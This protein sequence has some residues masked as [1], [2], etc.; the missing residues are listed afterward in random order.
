MDS[1]EKAIDS[2][3]T[4]N[5]TDLQKQLDVQSLAVF[6]TQSSSLESRKKLADQTRVQIKSLLKEYQNEIDSINKRSKNA[7]SAFLNL[8]KVFAEVADPYPILLELKNNSEQKNQLEELK[9]ENRK[10]YKQMDDLNDKLANDKKNESQITELKQQV[11]QY[12]LLLEARVNEKVA[13]L[14]MELKGEFD[15]RI[16][17][18]KE[19]E[20]SLNRQLSHLK[21]QMTSLKSNQ[22]LNST[23][24][25]DHYNEDLALKL[26]DMDI[27]QLDLEKANAKN[28]TLQ[29]QII[30]LKNEI[31]KLSNQS[32]L[33][34]TEK[35]VDNYKNQIQEL[36]SQI[37]SI[38]KTNKHDQEV[39]KVKVVE[40]ERQVATKQVEIKQ[41]ETLL[42]EYSDYEEIKRELEIMKGVEIEQT[43]DNLP[44][45]RMLLDKNKKLENENI[46]LKNELSNV[47]DSLEKTKD[48]HSKLQFETKQKSSL[49]AKLESDIHRLNE[50]TPH[51]PNEHLEQ[52]M[53]DFNPTKPKNDSSIIPILTSQRDRYRQ[54]YEESQLE[55]RSL[56]QKIS[57]LSDQINSLKQDNISLYEKLKYQ[58]SY[59]IDVDVNKYKNMYEERIDPFQQFKQ[60]E[61]KRASNLNTL[62]QIALE[63]TK[64]LVGNK[65]S[66]VIFVVYAA[67]LHLL[68]FVSLWELMAI[69]SC[70]AKVPAVTES[71]SKLNVD[72]KTS[73]VA[74]PNPAANVA[75]PATQAA[76]QSTPAAQL[77]P[78]KGVKE[79]IKKLKIE[80]LEIRNTLGTGSFG[81]VHLVK[82]KPTGK[83]YAMKV[84]KKAEIIKLRQVEH[85]M[86]EKNILEQLDFPFLVKI[87]GTFQ[88]SN[89]LYLV[90]EYVQGGELFTYLRKSGRFP[91]HVARFYAA[92]VVMAFEYL[93]GKDIIYRDLKP[94]NLLIDHLGHIKITDF[95]FAKFV[96]DVTWTLCGTPDYLAPEIIQS[97]GYGRAVDWWAL[98]ILIYEMIAGHPPFYDEDHF[99]LYEKILG[100]KL[101]FPSHFDPLAKDLVKRLLSPDLSKRFGNLKDGVQDI[102]H[103]KWFAGV[104]WDKLKNLEIPSPYVPKLSHEGDTSNFDVYPEDHEPYGATGPDPHRE[105]FKDF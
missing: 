2:W 17:I 96:P 1:Y 101:R 63:F 33:K 35:D 22:E 84:L 50:R 52:L 20:H 51:S 42:E 82:Y 65:Y 34:E 78:P 13:E 98:G 16:K 68:V 70:K 90:L 10:L 59:V 67:M 3:K 23:M 39:Y 36:E 4:V 48:L 71:L 74:A 73:P 9:N 64:L 26:A 7:E 31:Q 75:K 72:P 61:T 93:H 19:S 102:K 47:N 80:D 60:K 97:K 62:E 53:S 6:Q 55:T 43:D 77:P 85:T 30:V 58:E 14:T 83:H 79:K 15:E 91:N 86:N 49:I 45:E 5:L 94:E 25:A 40:L 37:H 87:L 46:S 99:K 38:E 12:E 24:N 8:Y 104:D 100:C 88:D 76:P 29:K 69:E 105:R 81:R 103:H 95:G 41:K 57:T 11:N 27:L 21:D 92:E 56:N 89:N 18:Y 44:L 32:V 28:G 54:R 66:R